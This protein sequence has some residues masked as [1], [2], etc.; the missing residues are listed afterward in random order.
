MSRLRR[1]RAATLTH[2]NF[3]R[4]DYEYK[5]DCVRRHAYTE[6][7]DYFYVQRDD[8]DEEK[9]LATLAAFLHNSLI[10]GLWEP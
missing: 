10:S 1:A 9:G 6:C 3:R 7:W 4:D 5:K 2:I 8:S